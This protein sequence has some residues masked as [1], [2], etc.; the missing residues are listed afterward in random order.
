MPANPLAKLP[1]DRAD[2]LAAALRAALKKET[3]PRVRAWAEKL[4]AGDR[5]AKGKK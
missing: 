3:D 4:L 1:T 5:P 2:R